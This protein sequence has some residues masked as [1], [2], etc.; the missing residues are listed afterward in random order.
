VQ[1]DRPVSHQRVCV[2]N[3]R[4]FN[5]LSMKFQAQLLITCFSGM[6]IVIDGRDGKARSKQPERQVA[7]FE[8]GNIFPSSQTVASLERSQ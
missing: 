7:V 4:G 5:G 1:F 3:F 2:E 8:I 6:I